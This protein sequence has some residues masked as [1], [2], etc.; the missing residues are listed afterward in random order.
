MSDELNTKDEQLVRERKRT[1]VHPSKRS[2]KSI[3]SWVR[4]DLISLEDRDSG[5]EYRW[6]DSNN[7]VKMAQREAQGYVRVTST[8][9]LHVKNAGSADIKHSGPS[10]QGIVEMGDLVLM[11]LETDL[12]QERRDAVM[13]LNREAVTGMTED[14]SSNMNRIGAPVIGD[15]VKVGTKV[16]VD[17]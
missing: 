2:K 16:K 13:E 17:I 12:A 1:S 7:K 3:K 9:D 4:G 15:G 11:A 14:L 8:S 10:T 5:W 6:C